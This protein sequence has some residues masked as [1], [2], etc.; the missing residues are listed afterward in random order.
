YACR[1]DGSIYYDKAFLAALMSGAARALRTDGDMAA[2]NP[3]AH[4]WGHILQYLL[5]T[6]YSTAPNRSEPDADCLAGVLMSRM[7]RQQQL[8]PG[9]L[10]EARWAIEFAGDAPLNTGVWGNVIE[11]LNLNAPPGSIPVI[12]NAMGDHGNPR[13]RLQAFSRG[14]TGTVASC[15]ANIPRPGRVVVATVHWYV[16]DLAN[17]YDRGVAQNKPTVFVS[18]DLNDPNFNRFKTETLQSPI[19]AQLAN[20]AIFVYSDPTRDIVA[21][22]AGNALGYGRLPVI[23]LLAP[24]PNMLDEASRIIGVLPAST[25][26]NDLTRHL[27]SR[28]WMGTTRAP[29]RPPLPGRCSNGD[30]STWCALHVLVHIFREHIQRHVSAAQDSVI[31][32]LEIVLRTERGLRSLALAVD[33]AMP[34]LVSAR[35]SWP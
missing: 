1:A 10:Q 22:N 32:R 33:F 35:L 15:T 4:E 16:N 2:V 29:W 23:S 24:N 11:R 19:F 21:R 9:D 30:V 3:L 31:K 12:T 20:Y 26:V 17:A 7:Q 5:D 34:N 25:I 8:Q 28:G 13:E 14:L 27:K 18:V 6:D